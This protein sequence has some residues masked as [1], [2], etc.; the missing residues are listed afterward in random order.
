MSHSYASN[1]I[2]LIFSTKNREKRISAEL[3]MKLW[4]YMA[5]IARNHRFE[6]VKV[7]GVEDHA[8]ALLL[9]PPAIALAKAVQIL[10]AC[11]SKWLNDPAASK[12][13]AWFGAPPALHRQST[14]FQ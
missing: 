1:R 12:D 11:S 13:F 7:G 6:A 4:P 9:L 3:Q 5:G 14:A 8:H 2:H 10:K